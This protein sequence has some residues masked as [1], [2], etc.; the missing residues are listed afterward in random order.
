MYKIKATK[1]LNK[2]QEQ[3][4][5]QLNILDKR[6]INLKVKVTKKGIKPKVKKNL[7]QKTFLNN[8]Q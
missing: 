2:A 6:N 1:N 8:D 7:I 4:F 5:I 3:I